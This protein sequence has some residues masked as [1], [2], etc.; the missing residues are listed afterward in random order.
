MKTPFDNM[1]T[2]KTSY[3]LPDVQSPRV[4]IGLKG[5]GLTSVGASSWLAA[6]MLFI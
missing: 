1:D 5:S 6:L 2:L 3:Q 4:T